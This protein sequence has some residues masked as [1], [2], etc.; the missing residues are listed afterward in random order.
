MIPIALTIAGSDS[1]GG[2]GIQADL[3]TFASKGVYGMSAITAVTAQNTIG[4]QAVHNQPPD[5][6]KL[7]I[8]SALSDIGADAIKIGMLANKEIITAVA[9]TIQHYPQIPLIV[10]PVMIAKS[11]DLLLESNAISSLIE[12]I[13]PLATIITPNLDEATAITGL[14]ASNQDEMEAIACKLFEMGPRYVVIKGGHLDGPALDVLYDGKNFHS[15]VAERVDTRNTHGTGCTFAAAITAEVAKGSSIIDAVD[16][17]KSYLTNSLVHSIPLGKGHGPVHHFHHLYRNSDRISVLEQL[18]SAIKRLESSQTGDLVPEVQS[19]LGM[20]LENPR[21]I[22][23]V[24]AFPGRLVRVHKDLRSVSQPEFGASSHVA[25]II[26]TTTQKDPQKRAVMNIRYDEAFLN[27]CRKLGL[28]IASFDRHDEPFE[29]QNR[30]GSSLEWGSAKV[31]QEQKFVPDIIYDQGGEGK[32]PMIRVIGNN[33]EKV[34]D[35][36]LAILE[37]ARRK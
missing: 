22:S 32:E 5:L 26:L 29:S 12:Q 36:V 30:E 19:N 20:S 1:G 2:A 7:Q 28:S 8:Q 35:I 15:F 37:N 24:A 25:R 10:D 9:E 18:T 11:G 21:S 23:D 33:P 27:S 13:L 34:T 16:R 6:V 4:V 17:A 31:I 14:K 3:K